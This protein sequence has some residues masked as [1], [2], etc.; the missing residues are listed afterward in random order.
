MSN[1]GFSIAGRAIGANHP[2]YIVA[3]MS[4]NH[5]GALD[6]ALA[7]MEAAK[8]AGAEAVKLQ[9]YTADTMTID[10]DGPGFRIEGGP[11]D[12]NTLYELYRQAHTP[13]EWHETLFARG[14]ALGITVFSSPFDAGAI[15]LLES[16]RAP[17]YKIASFEIVDLALIEAAAA[18]GKPVIISTGLADS[19]EIGEAVTTARRAGA[20]GVALL[21]CTSGYP[22]PPADSNLR[23]L[24]GLVEAFDVVVGLSDHTVGAAVPVAAVAL[25]AAIV[26]KH[27]TLSRAD[28]GPDS[29]FSLEPPE[30][31]VL[32]E[33][34]RTAWEA[35]GE[36]G[37][38]R[39]PS[40][41]P[42]AVF[43]R[44]IYVVKDIAE[45]APFT[46]E[47]LRVIRP[48][49]GL[50]PKYLPGVLGRPATRAL[51]RGTPLEW[52]F[53]AGGEEGGGR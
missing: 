43:R 29:A 45:G 44:S 14:R 1:A 28:G 19:E 10:H 17:A 36:A 21:Q 2:P 39:A 27:F 13:W 12:G 6:R 8:E 31:R 25:G 32:V 15:E 26:E 47:N 7:I 53:V 30:F 24:P 41:E 51:R 35:L 37:C 42:N 50:K 20:G 3:E 22:T 16:L 9:T 4:A 34:C 46:S 23:A 52:D 38:A 40:E 33:G 5:N 49:L 11:W 48:G 18:T